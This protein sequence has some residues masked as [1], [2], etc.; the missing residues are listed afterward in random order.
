MDFEG[1]KE[2]VAAATPI[3]RVGVPDDVAGTIAFLVGPDSSYISGQ[4]L[5]V[6][7]GP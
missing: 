3:P 5:Y 7:G 2:A 6:R 1:F 4:T